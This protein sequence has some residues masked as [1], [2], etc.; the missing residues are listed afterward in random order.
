MKIVFEAERLPVEARL[1]V[2]D[3]L[4]GAA[5]GGFDFFF[6]TWGP[7]AIFIH[8]FAANFA[9]KHNQL[10]RG[11]GFARDARFGVFG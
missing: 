6:G 4:D 5:D 11:Q 8:A 9:R 10:R 7:L 2:T 1:F 3:F